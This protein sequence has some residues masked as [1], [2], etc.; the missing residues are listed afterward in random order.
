MRLINKRSGISKYKKIIYL[1]GF[2][3]LLSVNTVSAA[4]YYVSPD[5]ENTNP[6]TSDLP[7]KS[8]QKAVD[9]SS[10]GCVIIIKQGIYKEHININRSG[11]ANHPVIIE[12]ER[13]E[14]GEWLTIIDPGVPVQGWVPAQEI[15][16][17]VYKTDSIDF[18]PR[19]MNVDSKRIGRINDNYMENGKGFSYLAKPENALHTIEGT[20][21]S[22]FYWDGIEV[23]Y[24][25]L[26]SK[27]YIRF[28]DKSDP[29]SKNITASPVNPAIHIDS[30]SFI[31]I[32][33]MA[34]RGARRAISI[35]GSGSHHNVIENNRLTNGTSRVYIYDGPWKN[36]IST[37]EMTMNYYGYDSFGAGMGGSEAGDYIKVHLY[38]E[39]KY[40]IGTG[41]SDDCGI[42]LINAGDENEICSNHIFSGLLGVSAYSRDTSEPSG[43]LKVYNNSIHNMSSV[44]IT[45]S[46]G[47]LG[48]EIYNNLIYDCNINI[49][50][51]VLNK[52]TDLGRKV[53][54]YNNRLWNPD[55]AGY[56]FYVH[57]AET[58]KPEKFPEYFIYHNSFSGGK[59]FM[60]I[61]R[62][63]EVSGGMPYCYILNNIISSKTAFS[64]VLITLAEEG[65]LGAFD[66]NWIGGKYPH[67][68]PVNFFG[69]HNVY[70]EN[71]FF[72]DPVRIP[73]FNECSDNNVMNAGIDLSQPF[74]IN[75]KMLDSLPG[76]ELNYFYESAPSPGAVQFK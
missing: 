19:E 40:T 33:N 16:E 11:S 21:M 3:I 36:I 2:S 76:I 22:V 28:R 59:Q 10:P 65:L 70:A 71:S 55:N 24:G 41:T 27:V 66:Y 73:D 29:N 26:D 34:V 47:N 25:C 75:G 15:G 35:T 7:F 69:V 51:H 1:L 6:G 57:S 37:N 17:G 23:L 5:G 8:I 44:G 67:N 68:L 63:V 30:S 32:R 54:I 72:F 14:N 13:G 49:R 48:E 45:S 62:A 52:K 9:M 46:E 31:I 4:V 50:L 64:T 61:M 38:K 39:F 20:D 56:H 43:N 58:S 12:G 42:K 60:G 18:D 53:Y 74:F